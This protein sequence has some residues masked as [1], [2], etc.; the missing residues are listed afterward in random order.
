MRHPS[1]ISGGLRRG[2]GEGSQ[3]CSGGEGSS[4]MRQT[5]Q[6]LRQPRGHTENTEPA[7]RRGGLDGVEPSQLERK[8][9]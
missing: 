2:Q 8:Q 7:L 5:V 9:Q 6:T 3:A 4:A 1:R